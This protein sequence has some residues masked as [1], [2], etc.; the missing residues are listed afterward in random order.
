MLLQRSSFKRA[1]VPMLRQVIV[2]IVYFAA[3]LFGRVLCMFCVRFEEVPA[4]CEF[5]L[6]FM[7]SNYLPLPFG[8]QSPGRVFKPSFVLGGGGSCP[9]QIPPG[10][11]LGG[12]GVQPPS[13]C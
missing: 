6:L 10:F 1:S 8:L 13:E 11:T 5:V 12:G 3:S 2:F 4:W 7:N 9:S